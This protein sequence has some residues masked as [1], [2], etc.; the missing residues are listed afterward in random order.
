MKNKILTSIGFSL[1][2]LKIIDNWADN[3]E[4]SRSRA[5]NK[6]VKEFIITHNLDPENQLN[7]QTG[8]SDIEY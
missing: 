3:Q 2:L 5:V 8:L 1:P 6:M 7:L 4:L